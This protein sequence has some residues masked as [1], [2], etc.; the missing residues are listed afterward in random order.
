[1]SANCSSC[2]LRICGDNTRTVASLSARKLFVVIRTELNRPAY[3]KYELTWITGVSC[4]FKGLF[5]LKCGQTKSCHKE[6]FA[7][8]SRDF[9]VWYERKKLGSLNQQILALCC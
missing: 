3:E 7:E 1:M 8:W 6:V 4:V 5:Y 2:E 9:T